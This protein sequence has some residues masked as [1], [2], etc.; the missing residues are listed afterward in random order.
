[1]YPEPS[2]S[3]SAKACEGAVDFKVFKS[4][5]RVHQPWSTL[6]QPKQTSMHKPKDSS[7]LELAPHRQHGRILKPA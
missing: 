4:R 3:N 7:K 1:M 6:K 2:L 5:S